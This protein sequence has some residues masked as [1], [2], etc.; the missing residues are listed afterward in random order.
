MRAERPGIRLHRLELFNWGTFD[1]S[2]GEVYI[3]RPEGRTS[4][5]VG[6]NGAGKSTLV[7]AILTLL[8]PGPIRNYNVAAGAKKTERTERSYV[9]GACD[10]QLDDQQSGVTKKYLRGGTAFYSVVL[11]HFHDDHTDSGFTLA[12]ILYPKGDGSVD[13]IHAFAEG[14]KSIEQDLAGLTKTDGILASLRSRGFKATRTFSEYHHRFVK[15][16][17][18]KPLA[19]D[20]FNQTVAV[21][22]IQSLNKFIRDHMLESSGGKERVAKLI[23][24]FAELRTA[25][26]QL[27]RVTMQRDT[28]LPIEKHGHRYHDFRS[29]LNQTESLL[30]A[31]DPFFRQVSV[32]LATPELQRLRD[33][34]RQSE[35]QS[36]DLKAAIDDAN[37]QARRI[38]NEIDIAGGDRLR[39]IPQ[40]IKI[41]Q[42][43]LFRKQDRRHDYLDALSRSGRDEQVESP[44]D[45]ERVAAALRLSQSEI[46]QS[47]QKLSQQRD[48]Q[49]IAKANLLNE[50]RELVA[51]LEILKKR[52]YQFAWPF[53]AT[54]GSD[55]RGYWPE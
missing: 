4:L 10:Q 41:E 54:A 3:A 47:L 21:K 22:D 19:M 5:L 51:E 42:E 7:D 16:A 24:H 52:Q 43:K 53:V 33:Q 15:R 25:H 32:R 9:L 40:L 28:L 30:E 14:S 29:R 11:A 49:V 13:H 39:E 50:R 8:V 37:D 27:V 34:H 6:R 38:R 35:K 48:E 18:L 55:L 26:R 46:T 12:Q 2:G 20:M 23:E 36:D 45:F 44:D 31:A 1:S 17:G